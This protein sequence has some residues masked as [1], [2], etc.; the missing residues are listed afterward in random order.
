[1]FVLDTVEHWL[2]YTYMVNIKII[3]Q[4][5][6]EEAIGNGLTVRVFSLPFSFLTEVNS[7]DGISNKAVQLRKVQ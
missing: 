6:R 2:I 4:R 7:N 1:M 5:V 3:E